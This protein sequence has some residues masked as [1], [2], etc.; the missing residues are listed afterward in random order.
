MQVAETV[1]KIFIS[2]N[3]TLSVAESCTGGT[4]AA[5]LTQIA[6]SSKYF[7][8][9]VVSYSNAAKE[10]LL[11]VDKLILKNNGPVSKEVAQAMAEGSLK[12]FQSDYAIATTGVAGPDGGTTSTPVGTVWMSI[13][14]KSKS[15]KTWMI[16]AQGN[17]QDVVQTAV[18]TILK[19]LVEEVSAT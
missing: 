17:R 5:L 19:Q 16:Q 2:K 8:G 13:A 3:F 1:H 11:K 7:L 10:N 9:G 15:T 6:G 12:V 18:D 4:I 14:S